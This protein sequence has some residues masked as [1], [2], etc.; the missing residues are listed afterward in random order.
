MFPT[1]R[2][3]G[4]LR[5]EGVFAGRG[6]QH[7]FPGGMGGEGGPTPV[8]RD[9]SGRGTAVVGPRQRRRRRAAPPG[10]LGP[11]ASRGSGRNAGKVGEAGRSI[12][13]PL[14]GELREGGAAAE[15]WPRSHCYCLLHCLFFESVGS[16]SLSP[17]GA[18]GDGVGG[19]LSARAGGGGGA[20]ISAGTKAGCGHPSCVR[21]GRHPPFARLI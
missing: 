14:G 8:L 21:G 15:D 9:G 2:F 6:H 11:V 18:V 20:R 10:S 16:I 12:V 5:N 3:S 17:S 4:F 13:S 19:A 1:R 7:F